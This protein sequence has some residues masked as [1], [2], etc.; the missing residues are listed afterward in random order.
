MPNRPNGFPTRW[1]R[2]YRRRNR[3]Q[4]I[5]DRFDFDLGEGWLA[6]WHHTPHARPRLSLIELGHLAH[7]RS[8]RAR[9]SSGK[10][11]GTR[12]ERPYTSASCHSSKCSSQQADTASNGEKSPVLTT[13]SGRSAQES[14]C[15]EL[16]SGWLT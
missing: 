2:A 5:D 14:M 13:T 12:A 10:K 4:R 1:C 9:R 6:P 3:P 16:K 11:L 7:G 8:A 15:L